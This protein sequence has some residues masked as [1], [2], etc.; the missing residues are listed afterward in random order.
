[1]FNHN[2]ILVFC[3]GYQ[4]CSFMA[5]EPEEKEKLVWKVCEL[6]PMKKDLKVLTSNSGPAI[7]PTCGEPV[8]LVTLNTACESLFKVFQ[9]SS[10][11]LLVFIHN[12]KDSCLHLYRSPKIGS[13]INNMSPIHTFKRGFDLLSVD[14]GAR[15]MALYDKSRFKIGIYKFDE[16]FRKVYGTGVEIQLETYEGSK[17]IKWMHLIPL[18]M[19]L[20]LVDDS[21]TVRVLEIHEKPMMNSK[22][23]SLPLQQPLSKACISADG[24]FFIVLRQSQSSNY[25]DVSLAGREIIFGPQSHLVLHSPNDAPCFLSSHL[26]KTVLAKEVVQQ[27]VQ[28]KVPNGEQ[29]ETE[30]GGPCPTLGYIYHIFDK[31][32]ITP[33]LFPTDKKDITFNIVLENSM[34]PCNGEACIKYLEALVRKLRV[35]KDKDFSNI[36]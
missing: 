24:F 6:S 25:L 5:S 20:L 10:G 36:S 32:A 18:K 1:M 27:E 31:F 12:F 2:R 22:H 14:E 33:A 34:D 30:I 3:D 7:V 15:S 13:N 16:S 8:E 28:N 19:E 35:A 4:R 9:L 23:I 21:N 17:V 29:G 26:L 11:E